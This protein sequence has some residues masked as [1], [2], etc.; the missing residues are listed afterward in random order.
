V[1][2]LTASTQ[3]HS[4][5][6]RPLPINERHTGDTAS[7]PEEA[8]LYGIE[9]I[10]WRVRSYM[11]MDARFASEM[12]V[13]VRFV[14]NAVWPSEGADCLAIAKTDID[15]IHPATL[16]ELSEKLDGAIRRMGGGAE[17]RRMAAALLSAWM[18]SRSVE[19]LG[20]DIY[21]KAARQMKVDIELL[22]T[23]ILL[24]R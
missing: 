14:L 6:E 17:P 19:A 21:R 9:E 23:R 8:V 11:H 10:M 5:A 22:L 16:A 15:R 20:E 18:K 24:R 2:A 7:S 3:A 4:S 1:R 13:A 12:D